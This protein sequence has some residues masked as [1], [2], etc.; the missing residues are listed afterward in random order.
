[1]RPRRGARVARVASAAALAAPVSRS[2]RISPKAPLKIDRTGRARTGIASFYASY[3][4]GRKMADGARMDPHGSNAASRTLPL[5]TVAKVTNLTNHRSA[6]VTIEDR[7]PYVRGR[8]VDL[9]PAT[10]RS[11]GITQRA[12]IAKVRVTPLTV[13]V[14]PLRI[15]SAAGNVRTLSASGAR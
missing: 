9:S 14:Q 7:G 4:A 11:I 3:F 15:A 13:P 8:I 2:S 10:A 1:M 12:G 5:G 6:V